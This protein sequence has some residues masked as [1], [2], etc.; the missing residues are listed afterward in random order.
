MNTSTK[1]NSGARYFLPREIKIMRMVPSATSARRARKT[2]SGR[3]T[4]EYQSNVSMDHYILRLVSVNCPFLDKAGQLT[5]APLLQAQLFDSPPA[6]PVIGAMDDTGD[7]DHALHAA[8]GNAI[9]LSQRGNRD[10][11][12]RYVLENITVIQCGRRFDAVV[13][14]LIM[15]GFVQ[16]RA[17]GVVG[18]FQPFQR[19]ARPDPERRG[20]RD[21]FAVQ[22][23]EHAR[24]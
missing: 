18:K 20:N 11:A 5:D 8:H 22:H 2:I 10:Q 15:D 3:I 7:L 4:Q 14:R 12:H 21:P 6:P 23:F 17:G 13:T 1:P 9:A 16:V 24:H 19:R